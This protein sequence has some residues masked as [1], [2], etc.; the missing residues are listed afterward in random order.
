MTTLK[1]S[2]QAY[3]PQQTKNIT[4]LEEVSVN[5]D[6]EEVEYTDNEGK[7]FT[8]NQIEIDGEKYRVPTSV[9]KQLKAQLEGN[10]KLEKFKVNR[11]G[12]GMQT[13]YTV[14]PL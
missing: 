2:A 13:E 14:I 12:Q 11:S 8:I 10:P 7:A 6:I 3:K 5:I 1:E 9:I 4:E